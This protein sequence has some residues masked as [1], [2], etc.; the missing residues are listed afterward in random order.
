MKGKNKKNKSSV[1]KPKNKKKTVAGRRSSRKQ[2][3]ITLN[4]VQLTDRIMQD[5]MVTDDLG[6][7][8]GKLLN[9]LKAN[10]KNEKKRVNELLNDLLKKKLLIYNEGKILIPKGKKHIEKPSTKPY[11]TYNTSVKSSDSKSSSNKNDLIGILDVNRR[12]TGFVMIE[13]L[14]NDIRISERDLNMAFKGDKVRVVLKSSN[15]RNPKKQQGKIVEILERKRTRFVGKLTKVGDK[16]WLIES[17]ERSSHVD[18]FVL[19]EDLNGAKPNDKV[20]FELKAWHNKKGMPQASIIEVFGPAGTKDAIILSILGEAQYRAGFPEDVEAYTKDLD[21]SISESEVKKR[22]DIRDKQ[23]FTI[24]PVDAKDFDDALNIEILENGNYY[25]GVHIADVT[26]FLEMNSILDKEA[27]NRATS[28]YLVDRVIP[29][30]PEALSNFACSLRPNE[31]KYSYSCFMEI[32]PRGKLVSYK[33]EETVIN[34][35]R[36]FTYEEA[37]EVLDGKLEDPCKEDLLTISKLADVLL[38]KRMREGSVKFETPEPKFILDENGKPL[39][40]IVKERLFA[41]KLIEECMLMANR[42]VAIYIQDQ[43]KA[44]KAKSGKKD[45]FPFFYRVHDKPDPKKL[46]VLA[47]YI[48]PLGIVLDPDASHANAKALNAI[49]EQV[50]GK[51]IEQAVN[52]LM[53]RSMSKAVYQ[54]DNIG[55][56]GLG[57]DNYAHF[58]S[59]IRRYPDVIVHRLLKAYNANKPKPPYF[60]QELLELG[61]HTSSQEKEATIAERE[62][63]KLKQVE[64]VSERIGEEFEGVITGL[65]DRGIYVLLKD[66]YCEGMVPLT[67]LEDDFYVYHQHLQKLQG[68][69]KGKSFVLGQDV[70]VRVDDTNLERRII[71]L[72]LVN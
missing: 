33:I 3:V 65:T 26:H 13:G 55:H 41:H 61:T 69:N 48:S 29:M 22:H 2:S 18:F 47:E 67:T 45:H 7:T 34:S 70:R 56:F 63:I 24:D 43:R 58:T 25:L 9:D 8:H 52:D 64:F 27:L 31:D 44:H 51:P 15:G 1:S 66:I 17:D 72:S 23:V 49:L 16:Q 4:D 57:F 20:L 14:E 50:E 59:P 46:A 53:V 6:V 68:N 42:T 5:V 39:E 12:G 30:L 21:L 36:R 60:Y 62:S 54:P 40:V 19:Q 37:Q 71:D 10:T 28:V 35:K 38:K 32:T 11:E